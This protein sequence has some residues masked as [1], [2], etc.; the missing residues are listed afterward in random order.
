MKQK[1]FVNF[2]SSCNSAKLFL[3]LYYCTGSWLTPS[4]KDGTPS[5][6]SAWPTPQRLF[7]ERRG[8]NLDVA[9]SQIRICPQSCGDMVNWCVVKYFDRNKKQPQDWIDWCWSRKTGVHLRFWATKAPFQP[10]ILKQK[11]YASCQYQFWMC[12]KVVEQS[13][14]LLDLQT[15]AAGSVQLALY[16]LFITS[17]SQEVAHP[18]SNWWHNLTPFWK[19]QQHSENSCNQSE[20]DTSLFSCTGTCW[21]PE[22]R[23]QV[24][25]HRVCVPEIQLQSPL[26]RLNKF[27]CK[28]D[29]WL[30]TVRFTPRQAFK[31]S[32]TRGCWFA[33]ISYNS[34]KIP[35]IPVKAATFESDELNTK[36][37]IKK[38]L[39]QICCMLKYLFPMLFQEVPTG[40]LTQSKKNQVGKLADS[41]QGDLQ[42]EE[43]WPSRAFDLS[44][45]S[46]CQKRPCFCWIVLHILRPLALAR[47]G[48]TVAL[49]KVHSERKT[50][51]QYIKYMGKLT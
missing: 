45:L 15:C 33:M 26:V 20:I 44:R 38:S 11:G 40:C 8:L 22:I 10:R 35:N 41:M 17:S 42:V 47:T 31:S 7:L 34:T 43:C 5:K 50:Y 29:A 48:I 27:Q 1:P 18:L 49:L 3:C 30:P 39:L 23:L 46:L 9:K 21:N 6:R 28:S 13:V 25:H 16:K 37:Q 32:S 19:F 24:F 4:I 36:K 2:K 12:V 51:S 14:K